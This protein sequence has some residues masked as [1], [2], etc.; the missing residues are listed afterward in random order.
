MWKSS[1]RVGSKGVGRGGE[2]K[3]G[4]RKGGEKGSQAFYSLQTGSMLGALQYFLR[5]LTCAG[6][7]CMCGIQICFL[8]VNHLENF[9]HL[10]HIRFYF[11][12]Y[13]RPMMIF[14]NLFTLR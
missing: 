14:S 9:S 7:L 10:M 5:L 13:K 6:A 3:E 4:E 8:M 2:R 11:L 1:E 12:C